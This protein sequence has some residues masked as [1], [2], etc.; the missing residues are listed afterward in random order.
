MYWLIR[1]N[2][3]SSSSFAIKNPVVSCHIFPFSWQEEQGG[4][5]MTKKSAPT[6]AP[7][8]PLIYPRRHV[9]RSGFKLVIIL[10]IGLCFFALLR[11]H[12]SSDTLISRARRPSI[13][14]DVVFF[15][16]P[17]KIAFLFLVRRELP[18]DF[19]WGSFFE[20]IEK[21]LFFVFVIFLGKWRKLGNWVH[22]YIYIYTYRFQFSV[23]LWRKVLEFGNWVLFF[24]WSA[25]WTFCRFPRKIK[26]IYRIWIFFSNLQFDFSIT[27]LGTLMESELDFF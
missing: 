14:R 1:S 13:S 2:F 20:V 17:P 16:G 25:I 9:I 10:S 24:G 7:I 8:L 18:L 23:T 22:S 19:L 26:K 12:F 5:R 3:P 11:L 4:T 15:T 6:T 21:D 27:F